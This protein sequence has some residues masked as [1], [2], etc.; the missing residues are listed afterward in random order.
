[1]NDAEPPSQR[2]LQRPPDFTGPRLE[3][4]RDVFLRHGLPGAALATMCLALPGASEFLGTG[5]RPLAATPAAYAGVFLVLF[6]ALLGYRWMLDRRIDAGAAG[7]TLYLLGVSLAEECLFRVV[8]PYCAAAQ[9][10]ELR[11]AVVASNLAFAVLH[12]FTLRWKWQWC[13]MAFFGGMAL[14]RLYHAHADLALIV[15]LH[16]LGTFVNTPR[17]P[18]PARVG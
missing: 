2:R 14:S 5:L 10:I 4:F 16:W 11:S 13:V 17:P 12:Y 8:L 7:W 6:L 3:R 18:R 1:M 15:A 9:G